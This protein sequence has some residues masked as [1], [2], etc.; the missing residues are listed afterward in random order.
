M[1]NM[2][3]SELRSEMDRR[4][5]QVEIGF[6]NLRGDVKVMDARFEAV[7]ARFEALEA[8]L[9]TKFSKLINTTVFS[10]VG[11]AVTVLSGFAIIRGLFG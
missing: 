8:R 3:N 5:T 2:D 1:E 4:F 7:T 11:L 6:A 9:D 10:A